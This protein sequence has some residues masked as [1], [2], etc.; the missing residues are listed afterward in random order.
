MGVRGITSSAEVEVDLYTE[1]FAYNTNGLTHEA[2][3]GFPAGNPE[4]Q[5]LGTGDDVGAPGQTKDM[6]IFYDG[7]NISL[8]WSNET[9]LASATTNF[10][11]G[12]ITQ[13]VGGNTA[14][15]GFTA[16]CGGVND[17]Q[18]VSD[19]SY[20]PLLPLLS[21]VS[22][23]SGGVL[24]SWPAASSYALQQTSS[25]TSPS[26][27]T[28]PGPYTTVNGPL[29]PQYQVHVTSLTGAEFYRL[30]ITR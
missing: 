8:T 22:D 14:Y 1:M 21:I 29:Y 24:V 28:I 15:V 6:T 19:F 5:I 9:S 11:V 20:V 17:T 18:I 26:W 12:D 23:G 3:N 30:L 25:L 16:A 27:S 2:A 13:A 10:P 4:F 7:Y